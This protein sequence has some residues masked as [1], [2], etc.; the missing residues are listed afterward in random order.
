MC[1]KCGYYCCAVTQRERIIVLDALRS[2]SLWFTKIDL[3]DD[4]CEF[5]N[6]K[7]SERLKRVARLKI[8]RAIEQLTD[9]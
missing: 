5:A 6:A 2:A 7:E 8:D 3:D 9:Q 4:C 1:S